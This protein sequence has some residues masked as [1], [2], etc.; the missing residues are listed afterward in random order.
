MWSILIIEN[1]FIN[2]AYYNSFKQSAG[3]HGSR[4]LQVL[5]F[6]VKFNR[7]RYRQVSHE[8]WLRVT[9]GLS[10]AGYPDFVAATHVFDARWCRAHGFRDFN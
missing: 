10:P 2:I 9:H 3:E 7:K 8:L 6:S 4:Y 5:G 1:R